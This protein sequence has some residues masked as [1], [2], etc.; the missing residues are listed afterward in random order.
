M[1]KAVM[2]LLIA[3]QV[4]V[5]PYSSMKHCNEDT[6]KFHLISKFFS[7]GQEVSVSCHKLEKW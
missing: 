1:I 4:S 5:Y 3:G 6:L 2:V 7:N